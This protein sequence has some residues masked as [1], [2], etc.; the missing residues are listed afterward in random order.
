MK[1]IKLKKLLLL[2]F[3][4]TGLIFVSCNCNKCNED[5][6]SKKDTTLR[7]LVTDIEVIK[8]NNAKFVDAEILMGAGKLKISDG[9]TDLLEAGFAFTYKEFKGNIKYEVIDEKGRLKIIQPSSNKNFNI[10]NHRIK[11]YKNIWDLRFNKNV[12]MNMLIKLG[13][14]DA[15]ININEL[16]IEK[17]DLKLGAGKADINLNN[18]KILKRVDVEMGVGDLTLDLTGD[19]KHNLS[20]EIDGGIGQ[21]TLILPEKV[22]VK[23]KIE[24]GLTDI[25]VDKFIKDGKYYYNESFNKDK[26][27][28]KIKIN[29]GIGQVNLEMR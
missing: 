28:I 16:L 21:L 26:P 12:P 5:Q 9:A 20:A 27:Y 10:K 6:K 24:K 22:G 3:I 8:L 11:G 2:S 18:S 25:N 29:T 15:E 13:A 7:K 19:W 1:S 4:L 23:A 17:L 14:G